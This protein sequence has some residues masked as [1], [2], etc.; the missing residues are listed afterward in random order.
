VHDERTRSA[1]L[2]AGGAGGAG[3]QAAL[4]DFKATWTTGLDELEAEAALGALALDLAA[5]YDAEASSFDFARVALDATARVMQASGGCVLQIDGEGREATVLAEHGDVAE[6][7]RG[8]APALSRTLLQELLR[9]GE[10]L[11]LGD[12]VQTHGEVTSVLNLQVRS[13]LIA[14][15]KVGGHV[16]GAIY[17][18]NRKR[19]HAFG[20]GDRRRLERIAS[21]L[22]PHVDVG[23]RLEKAAEDRR[24]LAS[25]LH[26]RETTRFVGES[27]ALRRVLEL[28][29]Q[30]A[31][32]DAPVL[33]TGESG[34][35]KELVA[36]AVH[37]AGRR[38]SGPFVAVSCAAIPESLVEAELFGHERGAFTGAVARRAGR[39]ERADGGTLFLDEVAELRPD[40]QAKLLRVLQEQSFERVGGDETLRVDARIVAATHRDLKALVAEGAFREDLYYRLHV[41][42]IHVPPL[43]E[44]REDVAPLALHFLELH[45]RRMGRRVRLSAEVLEALE[46]HDF[47]GNVRELS[48][49]VQ[50]LVALARGTTVGVEDLPEE[51][52]PGRTLSLGKD[53]FRRFRRRPAASNDELKAW[54]AELRAL[55]ERE[56]LAMEA[57]FLQSFLDRAG[58]NVTEAARSAGMSRTLFHRKLRRSRASGDEGD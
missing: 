32:T 12:A 6:A 41:I 34:S 22:G 9:T 7:V 2:P 39:F 45:G 18:E 56:S 25:T 21:V 28:V 31:D 20:D 23:E 44:R 8:V 26:S 3:A 40:L 4:A 52:R 58:G 47:P 14:P 46:A 53:P 30:V 42:P 27:A 17:L 50:R 48:N 54:R 55:C 29:E 24:Q 16:T 10:T 33:V 38:A 15:L 5:R 51:L 57:A 36:R 43:R 49:L 19:S 13:V 37:D 11:L 1:A 35:G